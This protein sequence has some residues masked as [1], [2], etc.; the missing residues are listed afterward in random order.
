[1]ISGTEVAGGFLDEFESFLDHQDNKVLTELS[2]I[3]HLRPTLRPGW[4]TAQ[5]SDF[6]SVSLE[7][8]ITYHH[9]TSFSNPIYTILRP[10]LLVFAI[11]P[12]Y[13]VARL[14]NSL[15]Q[16]PLLISDLNFMNI[17]RHYESLSVSFYIR[18][19]VCPSDYLSGSALHYFLGQLLTSFFAFPYFQGIFYVLQWTHYWSVSSLTWYL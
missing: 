6:N 14:L 15:S 8:P 2:S 7:L 19:Y 18:L 11:F 1:M 3:C 12:V 9:S 16:R 17:Y 13:F 5:F 10:F 4:G